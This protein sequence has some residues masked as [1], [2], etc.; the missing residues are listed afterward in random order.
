MSPMVTT[1][2][3]TINIREILRNYNV[4][5]YLVMS[6]RHCLPKNYYVFFGRR[7]PQRTFVF[8]ELLWQLN[9]AES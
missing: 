1:G 5:Y 6:L 3:I 2:N 4:T 7:V 9:K 8:R